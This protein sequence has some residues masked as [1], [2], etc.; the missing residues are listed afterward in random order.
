MSSTSY[1]L[2]D[3]LMIEPDPLR[4][5]VMMTLLLLSN[6]MEQIPWE[7]IN[8]LNMRVTRWKELPAV[9]FRQIGQA[10]TASYGRTEQL[11]ETIYPLGGLVDIDKAFV[12][13]TRTITDPRQ[14][15]IDMKLKA[16][17]YTFNY[18]FISG[19][20]SLDANGFTGMTA[21]IANLPA[22][23]TI[24]ASTNGLDVRASSAN[25]FTFLDKVNQLIYVIDDHKPSALYMNQNS[26][27][28]F[29]SVANRLALLN[30]DKDQFDREI[31]TYRGI[32]LY[33][34]GQQSDLSTD[35]ITQTETCGNQSASTSIYAV[36]FGES[37]GEYLHGI[38]EYPLDVEDLGRLQTTPAYR[39]EID[40][41]L[42]LAM[43]NDRSVAR[44]KGVNWTT[45]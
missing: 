21:R 37:G 40:W 24:T 8:T 5:G 18:Y 2:S 23:Q 32:P 4:A 33:D 29:T 9:G 28:G 35:I 15:Q 11:D 25:E 38:E 41:P 20:H 6:V 19:S 10:Y 13:D 7:S 22:R 44:L 36:R 30:K 31:L 43:W 14:L 45:V 17:V 39:T 12:R 1:R 27:L 42:G 3:H 26:Y 34:M 16:I